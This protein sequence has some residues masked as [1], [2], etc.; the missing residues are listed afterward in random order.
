ML[1]PFGFADN[2]QRLGFVLLE[3]IVAVDDLYQLIDRFLVLD[4]LD[5]LHVPAG[6]DESRDFEHEQ[7]GVLLVP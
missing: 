3:R 1:Q 2:L 4:V 7:A 6:L 5:L